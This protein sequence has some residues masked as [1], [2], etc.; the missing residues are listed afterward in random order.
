MN[1]IQILYLSSFMS[2]SRVVMEK[3][4]FSDQKYGNFTESGF[5]YINNVLNRKGCI[6]YVLIMLL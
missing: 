2:E 3:L 5:A 4:Y 6:I 1:N